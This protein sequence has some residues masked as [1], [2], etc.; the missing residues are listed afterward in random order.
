MILLDTGVVSAVLRRRR[1]GEVEQRAFDAVSDLLEVPD[2]IEVRVAATRAL[3]SFPPDMVDE[4]LE[5]I[6]D[7]DPDQHVRYTAELIRLEHR[8]RE[9]RPGE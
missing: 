4:V 8:L 5:R 2:A 6:A 3:S 1:R 7:S 9:K